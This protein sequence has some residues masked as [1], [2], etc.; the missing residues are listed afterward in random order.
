V[1][2]L[3][4]GGLIDPEGAIE[5]DGVERGR[6]LPESFWIGASRLP[7]TVRGYRGS[8]GSLGRGVVGHHL[9]GGTV[10]AEELVLAWAY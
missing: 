1:T 8:T 3:R 6:D 5:R 2:Y 10:G 9:D 4:A 7:S